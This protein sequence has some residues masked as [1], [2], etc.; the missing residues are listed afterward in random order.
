MDSQKKLFKGDFKDYWGK[1]LCIK[2]SHR[3]CSVFVSN[4]LTPARLLSKILIEPIKIEFSELSLA[5]KQVEL[6]HRPTYIV[7]SW[8][9]IWTSNEQLKFQNWRSF[10]LFW[11]SGARSFLYQWILKG[12]RDENNFFEILLSSLT[13]ELLFKTIVNV[14]C[15]KRNKTLSRLFF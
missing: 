5:S 12:G 13:Y 7:R 1:S 6:I 15:Q 9:K 8:I 14:L 3:D 4:L 2:A 11:V 10:R